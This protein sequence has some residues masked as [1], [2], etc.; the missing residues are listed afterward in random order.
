MGNI[1]SGNDKSVS[2]DRLNENERRRVQ[3]EKTTTTTTTAVTTGG[4]SNKTQSDHP[5]G[6]GFDPDFNRMNQEF[7]N[8][9]RSGQLEEWD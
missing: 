5:E 9:I 2:K 4:R 8:R 6:P 3:Q 7:R 1:M